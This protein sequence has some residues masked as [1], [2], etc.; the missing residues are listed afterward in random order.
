MI[1]IH[2]RAP[3]INN[4]FCWHK[5]C[6]KSQLII[7][8]IASTKVTSWHRPNWT[9]LDDTPLMDLF[10][11]TQHFSHK[12]TLGDKELPVNRQKPLSRAGLNGGQPSASTGWVERE[13]GV[14]LK[15]KNLLEWLNLEVSYKTYNMN[16]VS[17]V[18]CKP[19]TYLCFADTCTAN[20]MSWRLG[21]LHLDRLTQAFWFLCSPPRFRCL[22]SSDFR[23]PSLLK[24]LII[25]LN[26]LVRVHSRMKEVIIMS[27]VIVIDN[28]KKKWTFPLHAHDV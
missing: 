27:C 25:Y 19:C 20:I 21:C 11:E 4:R 23:F 24:E 5:S 26:H 2:F 15:K 6:W 12:Q 22:L 18:C 3:E 1:N 14:F 13:W 28:E 10:T 8:C 9:G 17:H 7:I 16:V